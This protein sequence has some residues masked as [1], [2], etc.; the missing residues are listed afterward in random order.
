MDK[1]IAGATKHSPFKLRYQLLAVGLVLLSLPYLGYRFIDATSNLLQQSQAQAQKQVAQSLANL[2]VQRPELLLQLPELSKQQPLLFVQSINQAKTIDGLANDWR[3]EMV[4]ASE[5][6][7]AEGQVHFTVTLGRFEQQLIGKIQVYDQHWLSPG[8][9][10]DG[11]LRSDHLRLSYIDA[12]Q[13]EHHLLL[14]GKQP[15]AMQIYQTDAQGSY[16]S[17]H[18]LNQFDIRASLQINDEGY[19]VEWRMPLALLGERQHLRLAV[20]DAD[21]PNVAANILTTQGPQASGYTALNTLSNQ[22]MALL[23]GQQE[24]PLSV[25]LYDQQLNRLAHTGHVPTMRTDPWNWQLSELWQQAYS[26]LLNRIMTS[27]NPVQGEANLS[28]PRLLN[29]ALAGI[30][31]QDRWSQPYSQGIQATAMPIMHQ[32]QP[33]GVVLVEQGID[34]LLQLQRQAMEQVVL[35]SLITVTLIMLVLFILFWR[36]AQRIRTLG[37]HTHA[38][39]DAYGRLQGPGLEYGINSSDELGDLARDIAQVMS[40]LQTHQS[41]LANIPRTLSHEIKNPLNTISTSLG[42]LAAELGEHP[43]QDYLTAAQRGLYKVE[44]ILNKLASAAS[45][46][47]ALQQETAEL[48]D[49]T[50]LL[51]SYCAYQAQVDPLIHYQGPHHSINMQAVDYRLEQALDKLLDNARDF[52]TPDTAINITLQEQGAWAKISV[53]NTGPSIKPQQA[54]HLFHSMVSQ[55][56]T[57]KQGG[58]GHFGLGLFVVRI[59]CEH[60]GGRV[61]WHN[62]PNGKGVCFSLHLPIQI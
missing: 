39:V 48:V 59:I 58:A 20:V 14:L 6:R 25:T 10:S 22:A 15:G 27:T 16:V 47:Q 45:L 13:Q 33:L 40:R 35:V 12:L 49:L 54:E 52:R 1:A 38:L 3:D 61:N 18:Q 60:H 51:S 26:S 41:F 28:R 43:S 17:Q 9:A 19:M 57:A 7:D 24:G 4:Q 44:G 2:F 34:Q 42:N 37:K 30:T 5:F 8:T 55:R 23:A 50:H 46:E 29:L 53:T 21:Q 56:P 36:L 32:Q 11:W 31:V 62:L